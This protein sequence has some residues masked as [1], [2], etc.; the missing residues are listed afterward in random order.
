MPIQVY[1]E[2]NGRAASTVHIGRMSGGTRENSLNTYSAVKRTVAEPRGGG[3]SVAYPSDAEW[4][5]G[6][7]FQHRYGDGLEACVAKGL[8]ALAAEES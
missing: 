5:A 1:I 7:I 3:Y 8:A 6:V 2:V 4:D